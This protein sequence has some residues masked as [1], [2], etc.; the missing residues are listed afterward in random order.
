MSVVGV[1]RTRCSVFS[2]YQQIGQ[3]SVDGDDGDD[4]DDVVDPGTPQCIKVAAVSEVRQMVP[5][6][7]WCM[8]FG[9]DLQN[10]CQSAFVVFCDWF[11]SPVKNY[12]SR[13]NK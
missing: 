9:F 1:S 2:N 13:Y 4:D 5:L 10:D 6:P 11:L 3:E 12:A 7:F 8:A